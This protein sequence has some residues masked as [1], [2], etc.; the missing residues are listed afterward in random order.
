MNIQLRRDFCLLALLPF[1]LTASCHPSGV[2]PD[3]QPAVRQLP[4][5]TGLSVDDNGK[6]SWNAV[7]HAGTYHLTVGSVLSK[8]VATNS[9]VYTGL[10]GT[11]DVSVTAVPQNP[12]I[13]SE[14]EPCVLKDAQFGKIVPPTPPTPPAST[15]TV[16]TGSASA[17]E[18][19]RAT[20]SASFTNGDNLGVYEARIVWGQSST[21]LNQTTYY[22]GALSGTSGSF[23]VVLDDLAP[24]TTYY[25]KAIVQIGTSDYSG[26]VKSFS[27]VGGQAAA[28]GL[29][30]WF[31]LPRQKDDNHD[32]I[33]DNNKDLYYSWTMR[34]DAPRIRNF[35][36]GYSK[37]RR[38]PYW[39][40]APMHKCY[41]GSSGRN[42]SYR[43][44]PAI[45]CEQSSKFDGYTRGHMIG[46]SERTVS[47]ATNKQ[48][49]FYSNIG[50]QMQSGFNTGGG[51]WN[52]LE[53]YVDGYWCSD[54]LYQVVGCIFDTFTDKHG[55]R[56]NA[57]S[58]T[59]G[60][61]STF[62]VPTA[63]YKVLLRTKKGNTGKR[64]DQCSANELQCVAFILPHKSD[65]G[66]KP[67]RKD[68]YSV[69]EVEELTGLEFFVNVPNA[70]KDKF[71]ASD[72]GL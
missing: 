57:K 35:S 20:V 16:T 36:A 64:V 62:Q 39:V 17:V 6:I 4:A 15:P 14:S 29:P 70:P 18:D 34:A 68:M 38:H 19:T 11:Y 49:F 61:G 40:A 46:S 42:D 66:H 1:F 10:S 32:G 31:E 33:D 37:S 71:S 44:D 67:D 47:V 58:G 56:I 2:E 26:S 28:T 21:S 45:S 24:G 51:A 54:T 22:N 63:W 3:P 52:N 53:S 65:K 60:A 13:F 23:D 9:Y 48:V 41:K 72:W 43:A 7:P 69:K 50:A 12:E 30:G 25:Y 5:P 59:N 27:T 55:S 8:S